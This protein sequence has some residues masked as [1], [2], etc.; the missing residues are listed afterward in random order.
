MAAKKGAKYI[1]VQL[2]ASSRPAASLEDEK[3][4]D[5]ESPPPPSQEDVPFHT[6]LAVPVIIVPYEMGQVIQE[7]G[8]MTFTRIRDP[9]TVSEEFG[10]LIEP[11]G[12][13][14]IGQ[15]PDIPW[16]DFD[17]FQAITGVMDEF[18]VWN[19][20][21][22]PQQIKDH[23]KTYI[24]LQQQQAADLNLY[25]TFDDFQ[26]PGVSATARDYSPLG[27]NNTGLV[28]A[29]PTIRN[30]VTYANGDPPRSPTRPEWI[31][32]P[33]S[34]LVGMGDVVIPV[35]P[36]SDTLVELKS[37]DPDGDD[38]HT[39]I[40]SEPAWGSLHDFAERNTLT[41][42]NV[43][44]DAN[45][46]ENKR[47]MF[48]APTTFSEESMFQ[49]SVDD[50]GTPV[51]ATV[52]LVP[53]VVNTPPATTEKV[54]EDTLNFFPLAKPSEFTQNNM[55]V[56]ITELPTKG[57]LFQIQLNPG[58][59]WLYSSLA[60]EI[61]QYGPMEL[62]SEP[63]TYLNNSRGIVMYAPPLNAFSGPPGTVYASF[64][65]KLVDEESG[66][67]S[68]EAVVGIVVGAENDAPE[69]DSSD[70]RKDS[71][72]V[73]VTDE[74]VINLKSFDV[75]ADT[76]ENFS[77]RTFARI[78]QF[79]RAGLLYQY[80]NSS[81]E[82]K[83][84]FM[85]GSVKRVPQVFSWASSV[86]RFS[87]Q[88]SRCETACTSWNNPACDKECTAKDY[89]AEQLL[90]PPDVYPSYRDAPTGMEFGERDFGHEWIELE[91]P[92]ELFING[93]EL[94]ETFKPG[95][96]WKVSTTSS[97]SD[98]T[99]IHCTK[100]GVPG[101]PTCSENTEWQTLWSRPRESLIP[102]PEAATVFS[103]PLCP[104]TT[105]TNVIRID[106]GKYPPMEN[107]ARLVNCRPNTFDCLFS[108]I[109][110]RYLDLT[111]LMLSN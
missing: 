54:K 52:R 71:L 11:A 97:Y 41:T 109:L 101:I 79:P 13:L 72:F 8:T 90:G 83:G 56:M 30:Q 14:T 40:V 92:F 17:P 50:G 22:S 6:K 68:T 32:T 103:P 34:P 70:I 98:D 57:S 46:T 89:N 25:Y 65:Y 43:V 84:A 1:V 88:Y 69:F 38:L 5:V 47:V 2:E 51:M 87:S 75:D 48:R 107:R 16:G 26:G 91:F 42:G 95:S 99:S 102:G 49:Y 7:R 44:V 15:E 28:G 85:D 77:E 78:T 21:R 86:V 3:Q 60:T 67:E 64:G 82:K 12:V 96:A 106:F 80:N 73:E 36:G 62:I 66:V 19:V 27:N 74:L 55:K 4:P 61:D 100:P 39:I 33:S 94:Y 24:P 18:R 76:F 63:G 111:I 29:L 108:Q 59:V 9:A 37:F 93:L 20:V 105:K 53:H 104:S 10:Q 58:K 110:P 31:P 35:A 23:Y 81:E 45:R